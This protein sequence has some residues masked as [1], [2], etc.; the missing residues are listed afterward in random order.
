MRTPNATT[1]NAKEFCATR[2]TCINAKELLANEG[3]GTPT[4][5]ARAALEAAVAAAEASPTAAA[6]TAL[7]TAIDSYYGATEIVVPEGGKTYTFTAVW[8]DA[9]YYIYNNGKL[10]SRF[11]FWT[12]T[13]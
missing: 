8:G 9:E 13:S 11:K 12:D 5:S 6:G 7:S 10:Q 4:G 3:I 1:E 2:T